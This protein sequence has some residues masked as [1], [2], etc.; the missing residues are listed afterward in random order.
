[1]A[2]EPFLFAILVLAVSTDLTRRRIPNLIPLAGLA[3]A[4]MV[5]LSTDPDRIALTWLGGAACG[6]LLFL[7]FYALR[8]MAAGDVK[9][10]AAVGAFVGPPLAL[11]IGL[12]AFVIGGAIGLLMLLATGRLRACLDNMRALLLHGALFRPPAA[13]DHGPVIVSVGGIPYALAVALSS[14]AVLSWQ[15]W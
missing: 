10:M 1:M 8:G 2:P 7:P 9:L 13:G 12:V 14:L 11:R 6:L 4:L 3:L 15:R 5:Q